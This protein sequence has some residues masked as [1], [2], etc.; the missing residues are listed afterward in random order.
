MH[1]P[2]W[3]VPP[4]PPGGAAS[5]HTDTARLLG[6]IQ[7]LVKAAVLGVMSGV[8]LAAGGA[9][10]GF[11]RQ[12][13]GFVAALI[14]AV[15]LTG[16]VLGFVRAGVLR[17]RLRALMPEAQRSPV[18]H[19]PSARRAATL[20]AY[21]NGLLVLLGLGGTG[22]LLFEGVSWGA[23]GNSFGFGA[24]MMAALLPFAL[25]LAAASTL[26]ELLRMVP[27]G[28]RMGQ[29][30]YGVFVTV[31][32]LMIVKGDG[33]LPKVVGGAIALVALGA[34]K[35]LGRCF[36]RMGGSPP[37]GQPRPAQRPQPHVPAQPQPYAPAP[38]QPQPQPQP[39]PGPYGPPAAS[40]GPGPYPP[41]PSQ[42][43]QGPRV[44][45]G[46]YGPHPYGAPGATPS[47][48]RSGRGSAV[49]AIVLA[50]VLLA[51][52]GLYVVKKRLLDGRG[53]TTTDVSESAQ[54]SAFGIAGE[55][56]AHWAT[57]V[58]RSRKSTRLLVSG[59]AAVRVA[60][61]TVTGHDLRTGKRLWE[62]KDRSGTY[63]ACAV[64]PTASRDVMA[65]LLREGADGPCGALVAIDIKHGKRLWSRR[66]VGA[67]DGKGMGTPAVHLHDGVVVTAGRTAPVVLDA[68][69]GRVRWTGADQLS[70]TGE[71]RDVESVAVSGDRV[72][73]SYESDHNTADLALRAFDLR[74]GR[75][76]DRPEV[77]PMPEGGGAS[78]DLTVIS[79][80]P[81]LVAL[82]DDTDSLDPAYYSRNGY[83][84]RALRTEDVGGQ[85]A[86][87]QE[88]QVGLVL[89]W[90]FVK[91]FTV[92]DPSLGVGFDS[93]VACFDLSTGGVMWQHALRRDSSTVAL[94]PGEVGGAVRA[95]ASDYDTGLQLFA[96]P[97]D[98]A[99]PVRGGRLTVD[100]STPG[101][102]DRFKEV[103][104]A[105]AQEDRLV[106]LN[107]QDNAL[108]AFPFPAKP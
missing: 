93:V 46:P 16:G 56:Q 86:R 69:T 88:T 36:Q 90:M 42:G 51:G 53:D 78:P 40:P 9:H 91:T 17:G 39:A 66:I 23:Y 85:N 20:A 3:Q 1:P 50:L 5:P 4:A 37:G 96:F 2:H 76:T 28:A 99:E 100:T 32:A 6:R 98:G 105:A 21:F 30:L 65:M 19:L 61:T 29:A 22:W 106:V 83:Q 45:Q 95:V 87:P 68:R 101:A 75:I 7:A 31:A 49:L 26:P 35:V 62:V 60:G 44:T 108:A 58:P 92:D 15:L 54:A 70:G 102:P 8:P 97:L 77:P 10:F 67:G 41:H 79:A 27:A 34:I 43:P 55:R 64:S 38:S 80:K 74:D 48:P 82:D 11:T 104:D 73:A 84:W 71:A 24:L 59:G 57:E 13:G 52:G 12:P 72:V 63:T 47:A 33:L 89:D 18:A 81:L 25:A 14:G 94:L 107:E 103:T